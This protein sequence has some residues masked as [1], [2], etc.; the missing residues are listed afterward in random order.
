[1]LLTIFEAR[2]Q[3]IGET[4]STFH[5]NCKVSSTSEAIRFCD[6][7]L[8][9]YFQDRLNVEEFGVVT[10]DTKNKVT[11]YCRVSIGTL[12]AS[13]VHPREVLKPAILNSA[14]SIILV[15]NHPSGDPTPSRQDLQVTDA[16][17]DAGKILGI[18]VLD[19]IVIGENSLSISEYRS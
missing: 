15:H 17:K 18:D 12:E 2:L 6:L 1:M 4:K 7:Q 16:M 14:S 5:A 10:L 9:E 11:G 19:H 13:L 8:G 3:K